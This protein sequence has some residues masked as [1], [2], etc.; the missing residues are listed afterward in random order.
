MNQA[1]SSSLMA[2]LDHLSIRILLLVTCTYSNFTTWLRTRFTC[3]LLD[4]TPSLLSSLSVAKHKTEDSASEKW[5]SGRSLDM[6]HRILCARCSP[7]NPM[8]SWAA[9]QP[10]MP[11]LKERRSQNLTFQHLSMCS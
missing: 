2:V 8:T 7:L 3:D 6:A 10:S 1:R 5:K 4:R 11:L 9:Q